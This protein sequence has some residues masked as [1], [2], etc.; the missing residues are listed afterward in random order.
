M[1]TMTGAMAFVVVVRLIIQGVAFVLASP[2][3]AL[4]KRLPDTDGPTSP[5]LM[6]FKSWVSSRTL[7]R[8]PEWAEYRGNFKLLLKTNVGSDQLDTFVNRVPAPLI[9]GWLRFAIATMAVFLVGW[10][11][12]LLV[13][14]VLAVQAAWTLTQDV[15]EWALAYD[16][17][18]LLN[19]QPTTGFDPIAQVLGIVNAIPEIAHMIGV[20]AISLLISIIFYWFVM[21]FLLPG[22]TLHEFGHYA[23]IRR[24]GASVDSYGLLLFGPLL[25]GAFVEPGEDAEELDA[26]QDFRIWS[27]GIANSLLWGTSLL[28]SGLLLTEQPLTTIQALYTQQYGVVSSQPVPSILLGVGVVEVANSFLNAVPFG[29]VDGGGFIRTAEEEWWDFDDSI[30]FDQRIRHVLSGGFPGDELPTADHD[31]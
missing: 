7:D 15:V 22:L 30:R 21:A 17:L 9:K 8:L 1:R 28:L 27:A 10:S 24:A 18:S 14:L 11:V 25:G 20:L 12:L 23:A 3:I 5:R 6:R 13:G 31:E 29:P 26:A 2:V 16:W 19:S 4:K